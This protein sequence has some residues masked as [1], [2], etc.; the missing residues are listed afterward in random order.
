VEV[1]AYMVERVYGAKPRL[2]PLWLPTDA[3]AHS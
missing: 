3:P 1:D 2:A